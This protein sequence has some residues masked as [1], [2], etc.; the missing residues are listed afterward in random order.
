MQGVFSGTFLNM[1]RT[2][3]VRQNKFCEFF[4]FYKGFFSWKSRKLRKVQFKM[5]PCRTCI[6]FYI[7][8]FSRSTNTVVI[9]L[10]KSFNEFPPGKYTLMEYLWNIPM[11]YSK[12]IRRKFPMRLRVIFRNNIPGILSVGIFLDCSIN[13]LFREY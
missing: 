4:S 8:S 3:L 13:I 9:H 2:Y 6:N 1:L 7:K 5:K 12:Y 10:C 11:R